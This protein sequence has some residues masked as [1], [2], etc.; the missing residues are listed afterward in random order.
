MAFSPTARAVAGLGLLAVLLCLLPLILGKFTAYQIGTY[1]LYGVAAQGVALTW[2]RTGF[3]PL[4]QALFFGLGAYI[5]G[6]L[7]VRSTESAAWLSLAP[8]VALVPAALAFVIARTIFHRQYISGAN[9]SLITMALVI[10]ATQLANR[11]DGITGGFNGLTNIPDLPG[12]GRYGTLYWLI[13][14][15]AL[16]CTAL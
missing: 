16:A 9:F 10:L 5:G 8:L 15:Y 7:L 12:F 13:A 11:W 6:I 1:L 14:G 3:L 4:G 2:G